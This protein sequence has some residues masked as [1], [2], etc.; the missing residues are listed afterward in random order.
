MTVWEAGDAG[1]DS[2]GGHSMFSICPEK[3]PQGNDHTSRV[4]HVLEVQKDYPWH[5]QF[6]GSR[7]DGDVNE[8]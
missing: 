6:I 8:T 1:S 2:C 4:E 7:V 3:Q 5:L